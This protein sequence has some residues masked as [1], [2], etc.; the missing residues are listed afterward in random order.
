MVIVSRAAGLR[1]AAE[2]QWSPSNQ[3]GDVAN[4]GA[5]SGLYRLLAH[6]LPAKG[7]LGLVTSNRRSYFNAGRRY[8][9]GD[10]RTSTLRSGCHAAIGGRGLPGPRLDPPL[11]EQVES[12]AWPLETSDA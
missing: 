6:A 5:G 12:P 1:L 8:P 11:P 3:A 7:Q 10:A 2:E 4:M 9:T